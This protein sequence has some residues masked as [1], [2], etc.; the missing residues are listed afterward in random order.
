MSCRE[1]RADP[2]MRST[3]HT[4]LCRAL[5][6]WFVAFPCHNEMHCVNTLSMAPEYKVFRIA[7]ETLNF[8][9]YRSW[10]S[11]CLAFLTWVWMC[12]VQFRSSG[13][14][15]TEVLEAAHPLHRGPTDHKRSLALRPATDLLSP[16]RRSYFERNRWS[17]VPATCVGSHWAE[18]VT[19]FSPC[20]RV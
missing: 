20:I 6:S 7:G 9:S 15:Y 1:G 10:Y 3:K 4:T 5:Q 17:S 8:L 11:L 13:D 2:E 14:A 18:N 16:L 12:A 19:Q